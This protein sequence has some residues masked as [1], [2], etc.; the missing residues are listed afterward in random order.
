MLP[1]GEWITRA[2]TLK[3]KLALRMKTETT[4]LAE[5]PTSEVARLQTMPT[6]SYEIDSP[7]LDGIYMTP[8]L[9]YPDGRFYIKL[10]C[11]T[12]TDEA[13]PDLAAMQR[14]MG[15]G[16]PDGMPEAMLQALL[17]FMPGLDVSTWLGK[18]CVLLVHRAAASH[19]PPWM[20]LEPATS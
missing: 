11:D 14:W 6:L 17:T 15:N 19:T 4:L 2:P 16:R 8:P 12:I 9:R 7:V 3:R 10:G 5:V 20:H 18:P 1:E 13:L